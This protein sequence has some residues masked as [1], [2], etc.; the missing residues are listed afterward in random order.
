MLRRRPARLLLRLDRCHLRR[1]L[2]H[3]RGRVPRIIM[4]FVFIRIVVVH[5]SLGVGVIV[6]VIPVTH[7]HE[8]AVH[9]GLLFLPILFFF[10]ARYRQRRRGCRH[11]VIGHFYRPLLPNSSN[12]VRSPSSALDPVPTSTATGASAYSAT[13]GSSGTLTAGA[14]AVRKPC[15]RRVTKAAVAA[16]NPARKR[17]RCC[18]DGRIDTNGC[19]I[20][21]PEVRRGHCFRPWWRRFSR[22][23][24]GRRSASTSTSTSI[25]TAA[26]TTTATT[27]YATSGGS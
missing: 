23:R 24:I 11:G 3:Y 19:E 21:A 14:A 4:V 25:A 16:A 22:T 5:T 17:V 8:H 2:R 9:V 15:A 26:N 13:L 12:A 1:Q 18:A 7:H 27:S 10:D 6:R 20:E